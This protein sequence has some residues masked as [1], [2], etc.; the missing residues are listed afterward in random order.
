MLIG[1][2]LAFSTRTGLCNRSRLGIL[3]TP[4]E[5]RMKN[6]LV[7]P[8]TAV[9][10]RQRKYSYLCCAGQLQGAG[11][12]GCAGSRGHHVVNQKNSFASQGIFLPGAECAGNI[13]AAL[14]VC[15]SSL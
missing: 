6:R 9:N 5:S 2:K 7:D 1:S 8:A 3:K 14:G 13:Q 12:C 4:G 10:A 11:A 15:Q